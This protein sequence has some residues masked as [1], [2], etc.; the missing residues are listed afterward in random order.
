MPSN[1]W[2]M[3]LRQLEEMR[4]A[5]TPET[6]GNAQA[7]ESQRFG[8]TQ[9]GADQYQVGSYIDPY[10]GYVSRPMD[11]TRPPP[12]RS[13]N[14]PDPRSYSSNLLG[15][16]EEFNMALQFG[17]MEVVL[18]KRI[19]ADLSEYLMRQRIIYS[20]AS[21][22]PT[23]SKNYLTLNLAHGRMIIR[24]ENDQGFASADQFD[25]YMET[26]DEKLP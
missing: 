13:L 5:N 17:I 23:P 6:N 25:R 8:Y 26:V 7:S 3:T 15:I 1:P 19:Y 24:P 11:H 2:A 4:V 16:L 10:S 12:S 18:D 22:P 20:N 9:N 21:D 14:E